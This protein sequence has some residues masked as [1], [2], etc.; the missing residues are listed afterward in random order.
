M[1]MQPFVLRI[2][3]G[4]YC[5]FGWMLGRWALEAA[6]WDPAYINSSFV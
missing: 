3:M 1:A 5:G 4:V 2:F 6:C